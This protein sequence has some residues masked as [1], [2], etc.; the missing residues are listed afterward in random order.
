MMM[1]QR[2]EQQFAFALEVD[3]LKNIFRQTRLSG[4][5][6]RENDA[7][8]S[9]HI[10]LMAYLFREYAN[11]EVDILRVMLMCL[12]HD[13][14][15]IDAGDTYAYDAQGLETQAAREAAARERLY[16]IL[17]ED[18]GAELAAL[19]DEFEACET[20]EARFA[21]ALDNIQPMMLNHSNGGGD[22]REH[23]IAAEQV[24]RRQ[25][26]TRLGSE[27]LFAVADEVIRENIRKGNLTE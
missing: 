2:M 9:W 1:D 19:F 24:Y 8:H 22:W 25:S 3:K 6:R 12:V 10:A 21:R 27:K 23:G 14:V 17:P 20:P 4:H 15:E 16:S 7:E 13:I 11:E 5:G 18:Q 26:R